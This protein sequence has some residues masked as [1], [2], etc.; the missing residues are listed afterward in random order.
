MSGKRQSGDG[1]EGKLSRR[2]FL[3]AA[4]TGAAAVSGLGG[5]SAFLAGCSSQQREEFF[6]KR[7]KELSHAEVKA[8]IARL[9]EEARTQHGTAMQISARPPLVGVLYGYGLD[10]S[11]CIGCRRCVYGCF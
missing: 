7:F 2:E 10:I 3:A 1:R 8:I 4:A 11:R 5:I 9:E 6:Q